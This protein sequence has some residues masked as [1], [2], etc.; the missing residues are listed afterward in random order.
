MTQRTTITTR[1]RNLG[2]AWHTVFTDGEYGPEPK[3]SLHRPDVVGTVRTVR[4]AMAARHRELGPGTCYYDRLFVGGVPVAEVVPGELNDILN[5]VECCGSVDVD[6]DP[7][8]TPGETARRIGVSRRT[9]IN[10]AAAGRFPGAWRTPGSDKRAGNWR[11]PE[12]SVA[13][14]Q[15]ER[16]A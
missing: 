16:A 6:L 8:L 7:Y 4:R 5:E 14:V 3:Y 10:W 2:Y 1:S 13:T 15:A 9:V 12:S 11:L